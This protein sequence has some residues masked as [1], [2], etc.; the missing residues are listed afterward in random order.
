VQGKKHL[1]HTTENAAWQAE[2]VKRHMHS[3]R[4]AADPILLN[5]F[6]RMED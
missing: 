3:P 2:T 1:P 4:V 6:R 5:P